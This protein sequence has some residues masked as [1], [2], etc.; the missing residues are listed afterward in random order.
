MIT[1]SAAA[2]ADGSVVVAN[3]GPPL[4]RCRRSRSRSTR[5]TS[6]AAMRFSRS[7]LTSYPTTWLP[8]ARNASAVG[9]PT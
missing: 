2:R 6:V 4:N 3:V 8:A 1:A 5:S 7:R 9:R